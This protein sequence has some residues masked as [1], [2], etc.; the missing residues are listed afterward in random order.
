MNLFCRGVFLAVLLATR[1]GWGGVDLEKSVVKI[2]SSN[3]ATSFFLNGSGFYFKYRDLG[4]ILTSEHILAPMTDADTQI[5]MKTQ[6]GQEFALQL[7][8]SD[9]ANG[10]ALLKVMKR[11]DPNDLQNLPDLN[12]LTPPTRISGAM[13]SAGFPA[14]SEGVVIDPDGVLVDTAANIDLLLD[15]PQLITV[16]SAMT[17]FGMSGGV[18]LNEDLQPLGTL[19][20]KNKDLT[21]VI[22]LAVAIPWIQNTI[23]HADFRPEIT[24]KYIYNPDREVVVNSGNF[25]ISWSPHNKIDMYYL[26]VN[27]FSMAKNFDHPMF[28]QAESLCAYYFR[29]SVRYYPYV[30]LYGF[31]KKGLL[32]VTEDIIRVRSVNDFFRRLR[33]D[34]LQPVAYVWFGNGD[35]RPS[36]DLDRLK[37]DFRRFMSSRRAEYS[38][39]NLWQHMKA[40]LSILNAGEADLVRLSPHDLEFALSDPSLQEDW[41]QMRNYSSQ[42]ADHLKKMLQGIQKIMAAYVL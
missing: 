14:A 41:N 10:L 16:R 1:L 31:R 42:D 6:D 24:R 4:L 39:L 26:R 7:L 18:L 15:S 29:L 30:H 5:T 22:P 17:E 35:A 33:D 38:Q 27:E 19:S 8:K 23:D 36:S 32:N 20:H 3:P 25:D 2:V 34:R 13:I 9:W 21:Y 12:D 11:L 40:L 37:E 28:A